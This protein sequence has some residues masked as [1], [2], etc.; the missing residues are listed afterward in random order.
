MVGDMFWA[1]E[2]RGTMH[3]ADGRS[4]MHSTWSLRSFLK[5]L[6][7]IWS[8]RWKSWSYPPAPAYFLWTSLIK[9]IDD[10][11][12][13]AAPTILCKL[14][15]F[16]VFAEAVKCCYIPLPPYDPF[17][18]LRLTFRGDARKS[19]GV[20]WEFAACYRY[21][22]LAPCLFRY[23]ATILVWLFFPWADPEPTDTIDFFTSDAFEEPERTR[24]F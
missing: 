9:L 23:A 8:I 2:G 22:S 1:G 13:W 18:W 19:W 14:P 4:G 17:M 15:A 21:A 6:E 12:L 10:W 11:L 24:S 3:G 20:A 16:E 7:S 5:E